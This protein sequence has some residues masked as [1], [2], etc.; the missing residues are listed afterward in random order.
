MKKVIIT[1]GGTGGHIFPAEAIAKGLLKAGYQVIFMTDERGKS[2]RKLNEIPTKVIAATSVTGR[3]FFGKI[4]ALFILWLG[5]MQSVLFL[6]KE[7]PDLVIGVGGYASLPAV[8]AAQFLDKFCF[9]LPTM[10]HE[11]NA[12]LG[13]ANRLLAPR[14]KM[15]ATAFKDTKQV[16]PSISTFWVGQPVRD[17]VL[18]KQK[19]PYSTEGNFH[20]LITGGSQGARFLSRKLPEALLKLPEDVRSNLQITQQARA[21]DVDDLQKQYQQAGFYA[22][23]VQSFFE[24]IP[25]LL[26]HS[27]LVI[28]R[29][30]SS[31]LAELAIVGRPGVFVPLPTSADNHQFENARQFAEAGAGWLVAEKDFDAEK[32]AA[33]LTDL[34]Q[35]QTELKMAAKAV[36]KL[37]HP[38]V[39]DKM[40]ELVGSVLKGLK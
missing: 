10:V 16:P 1:T 13:R 32:L 19:A 4:K 17:Q 35:N 22:T 34:I 18:A 40:V 31:T 24:D 29:S 3:S 23:T 37:G 39:A 21:E 36:L 25:T 15:I 2:F 30:G 9:R 7:K 6:R 8:L 11:Q 20:L 33:R 27:N 14:V 5:M 12:V 28:C 26:A 38:D